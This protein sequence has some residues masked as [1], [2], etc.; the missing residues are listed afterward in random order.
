MTGWLGVVS[1]DHVARGVHLGI[2]QVHHGKRA[3]LARMR[4]GDWIVYY[5]PRESMR[6]GATLK[7]FTAIGCLPDDDLWQADEGDFKPWRRRVDYRTEARIVPIDDLRGSLDLTAAPGW[8]QHLRRGLIQLTDHE[9]SLV[10]RAMI[11][12][13]PV[14]VPIEHPVQVTRASA[15]TPR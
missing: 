6:A 4:A 14:E 13:P 8:G 5:S 7:A 9:L 3:G 1:A 2:A 10:R 15:H 11:G 12:S